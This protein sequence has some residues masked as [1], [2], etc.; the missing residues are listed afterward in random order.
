MDTSKTTLLSP[1][2]V[3]DRV[4]PLA[5]DLGA[6]PA[7]AGLADLPYGRLGG[8]GFERLCYEVLG[9]EGHSPRF[10]GR[11]GQRDYGVD[12]VVEAADERGVYQCKNLA[13][14]PSW[15]AVRDAVSKFETDWLGEA[16][17][18]RPTAFVY[19]C[20]H[21]LDDHDLGQEWTRFRDAFKQRT[22]VAISFWDKDAFDTRLKRLPD[23]VA[24]LFSNFYAEHFCKRDDWRDSPWTRVRWGTRGYRSIEGF[25]AY[26]REE[27]IQVSAQDEER[28][29]DTLSASPVL[30]IRGL[31]GSGKSMTG[32]ELACRLASPLRRIYYAALKDTPDRQR[33]WQSVGRRRSLPCVFLLDD[34][35]LIL[36]LAGL[37]LRRLGLEGTATSPV[38]ESRTIR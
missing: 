24:G 22:G 14:A 37:F 31:P 16:G 29:L 15:T 30:A 4:D 2:E 13:E 26:R 21:P 6:D 1:G 8:P 18:P 9:S 20:P 35:H 10:F 25:L 17:L 33:L 19:C 36:E 12:I 23:L 11:S 32:L 38:P 28:F 27:R 3:W 5:P 34:C 7:V